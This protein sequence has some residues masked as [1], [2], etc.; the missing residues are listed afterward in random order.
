MPNSEILILAALFVVT[1]ADHSAVPNAYVVAMVLAKGKQL[2]PYAIFA[3][4]CVAVVLYENAVYWLGRRM[5]TRR[6]S[7]LRVVRVLLRGSAS[8]SVALGRHGILWLVFGRLVA[9]VGLYVPFAAGQMGRRYPT[10]LACATVGT[11]AHLA[12]FGVAAYMLGDLVHG[13]IERIGFGWIGAG[14]ALVF[15]AGQALGYVRRRR[16]TAE[17]E[18]PLLR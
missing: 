3:T 14:V 5:R 7:R 6:A 1:V 10:F 16:T 2:D 17:D 15:A 4:A 18:E 13:Y 8:V 9:F 11:L 12:A